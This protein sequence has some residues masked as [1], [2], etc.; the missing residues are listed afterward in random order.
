MEVENNVHSVKDELSISVLLAHE[1]E[2]SNLAPRGYTTFTLINTQL[3][4]VYHR[5]YLI[6]NIKSNIIAK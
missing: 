5:I 4:F 1:M 3:I 2:Q 6:L